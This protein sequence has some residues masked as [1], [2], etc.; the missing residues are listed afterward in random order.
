[1]G[2]TDG[3]GGERERE[4]EKNFDGGRIIFFFF[5][6]ARERGW[7]K[8]GREGVRER[9]KGPGGRESMGGRNGRGERQRHREREGQRE[10]ERE[11]ERGRERH[12]EREGRRGI[13]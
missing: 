6:P 4:G 3:R 11:R 9:T 12:I 5:R 1:M 13:E 8:G 2:G 10:R 7:R